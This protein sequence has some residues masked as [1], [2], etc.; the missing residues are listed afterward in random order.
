M[1]AQLSTAPALRL[2][3]WLG[4]SSP[5]HRDPLGPAGERAAERLLRR[6]GYALIGRNLRVP[7]GEADLLMIDP[8][9]ITIVLVEVKARRIASDSH[10]TAP[11][12]PPEANVTTEK[13]DK[14]VKILRHLAACNHWSSR[15]LRIDVVGVDFAPNDHM[16]SIRH[17]L[18]A[19]RLNA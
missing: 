6:K 12:L 3:A 11:Q 17:H 7:M 14:L 9:G 10:A 15:P 4:L 16:L 5:S 19:V 2:L 13:R 18:Q 1:I 8:D